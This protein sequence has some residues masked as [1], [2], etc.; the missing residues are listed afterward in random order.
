MKKRSQNTVSNCIRR[1]VANSIFN[2]CP[3]PTTNPIRTIHKRSISTNTKATPRQPTYNP[4][5]K[6]PRNYRSKHQ[7]NPTHQ[8]AFDPIKKDPAKCK[9][10]QLFKVNIYE[11]DNN[12]M[13][14]RVLDEILFEGECMD[15]PKKDLLNCTIKLKELVNA[16]H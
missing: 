14:T 2:C 15:S 16:K 5:N 6:I 10:I 1:F 8:F 4:I 9:E 11:V 3:P 13:N 7:R 12:V